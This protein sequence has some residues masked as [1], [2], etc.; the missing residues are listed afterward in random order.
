M[1]VSGGTV[2]CVKKIM[3]FTKG[4]GKCSSNY[5]FFVDS[6]FIVMKTEEEENVEEIY[7]VVL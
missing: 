2:A 1:E 3:R 6:W 7:F 4:C 5:T